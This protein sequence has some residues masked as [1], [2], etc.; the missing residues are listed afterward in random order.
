MKTYAKQLIKDLIEM[1]DYAHRLADGFLSNN[2]YLLYQ[3]WLGR[4]NGYERILESV[5]YDLDQVSTK[6]AVK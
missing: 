6:G 2:N 1:S 4:A 3:Y 5:R